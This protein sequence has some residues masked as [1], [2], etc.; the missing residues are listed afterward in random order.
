[1]IR[2]TDGVKKE[3]FNSSGSFCS[4]FIAEEQAIINTANYIT[5]IFDKNPTRTTDIVIFTDS[6]STLPKLESGTDVNKELK[7]LIWSL[8]NL[9]RRHQVRVV[10]QWIPAH[11]GIPGNERGDALAKQ[12]AK[13]SLT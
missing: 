1:M 12:G 4:N 13:P 11:A 10:L 9:M 2:F 5:Y 7:Q 3:V 8:H 6:L